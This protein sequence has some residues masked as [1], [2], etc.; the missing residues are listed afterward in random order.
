MF[1]LCS[2][3]SVV[4]L[5][6]QIEVWLSQVK[7]RLYLGSHY[8]LRF[9][10]PTSPPQPLRCARFV[11]T[12]ASCLNAVLSS[13]VPFYKVCVATCEPIN[14]D[15]FKSQILSLSLSPICLLDGVCVC[16]L[17]CLLEHYWSEMF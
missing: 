17:Q 10:A 4:S 6:L 14:A 13:S 9:P 3:P 15:P 12:Q 2:K 16:V 11:G 5:S 1:L 8:L 7:S